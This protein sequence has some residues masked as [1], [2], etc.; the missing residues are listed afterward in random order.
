MKESI[1][2]K[3]YYELLGVT[4]D[5]SELEIRV[6]YDDLRRIYDPESRFFADIIDEP[7]TPEQI[8]IFERITTAYRTLLEPP[9]RAAYDATLGG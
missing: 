5:A 4:R 6:A 2:R 9:A 7:I 3:T 1:S 8:Q